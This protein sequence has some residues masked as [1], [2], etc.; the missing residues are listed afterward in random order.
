MKICKLLAVV[1]ALATPMA[2]ETEIDAY[3][4]GS[5]PP[6]PEKWTKIDEDLSIRARVVRDKS[7]DFMDANAERSQKAA[8]VPCYSGQLHD[9]DGKFQPLDFELKFRPVTSDPA[10]TS[11][12]AVEVTDTVIKDHVML[13][14]TYDWQGGKG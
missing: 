11:A 3:G 2:A 7:G 14:P 6:L 8:A 13:W 12:V 4:L 10:G 1:L 9:A 5:N